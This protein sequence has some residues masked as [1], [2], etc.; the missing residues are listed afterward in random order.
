MGFVKETLYPR[1]IFSL[2]LDAIAFARVDISVNHLIDFGKS[3]RSVPEAHSENPTYLPNLSKQQR[4][5]HSPLL[6]TPKHLHM[7][8]AL[9]LPVTIYYVSVLPSVLLSSYELQK[10]HSS[11]SSI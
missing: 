7:T 8:I 4:K 6:S 10:S 1:Y 5:D 9:Y 2:H 3:S 11:L